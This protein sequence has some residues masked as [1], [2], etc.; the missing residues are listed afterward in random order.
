M[1]QFTLFED[2][3]TFR[4]GKISLCDADDGKSALMTR[5]I[6]EEP[7]FL[8]R[9]LKSYCVQMV[10]SGKLNGIDGKVTCEAGTL[11]FCQKEPT[12]P[13]EVF[14][15]MSLK[16]V[17]QTFYTEMEPFFNNLTDKAAIKRFAERRANA[18]STLAN[19]TYLRLP[20]VQVP[21]QMR[22]FL[23]LKKSQHPLCGCLFF[24]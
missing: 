8:Q 21:A 19:S 20:T 14:S 13:V 11:I 3:D 6:P 18:N 1:K 16:M 12:L 23:H 15:V 22:A 2:W 17:L 24:K 9:R 4:A 7:A 10:A 5:G